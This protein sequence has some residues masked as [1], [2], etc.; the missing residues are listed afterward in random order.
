MFAVDQQGEKE[1]VVRLF[2]S[3]EGGRAR[4]AA[5]RKAQED[6]ERGN[7]GEPPGHVKP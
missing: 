7:T 4:L 1:V 3:E 6:A 2:Q 5:E